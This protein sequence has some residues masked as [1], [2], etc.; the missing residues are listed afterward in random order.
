MMVGANELPHEFTWIP[1]CSDLRVG[2]L[3][4]VFHGAYS[5]RSQSTQLGLMPTSVLAASRD[6]DLHNRS[7]WAVAVGHKVVARPFRAFKQR[8]G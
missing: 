5:L 6:V 7:G 2:S 1:N 8:L 3:G 4:N